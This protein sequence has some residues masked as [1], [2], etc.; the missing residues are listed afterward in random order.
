MIDRCSALF[1]QDD[2]IWDVTE[3]TASAHFPPVEL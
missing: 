1:R 2:Q 3:N